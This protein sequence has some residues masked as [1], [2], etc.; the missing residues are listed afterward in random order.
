[1]WITTSG[2]AR[3]NSAAHRVRVADLD[4][5][6]AWR[7][8]ASAQQL[9]AEEPGRAGDVDPHDIGQLDG[10][11]ARRCLIHSTRNATANAIASPTQHALPGLLLELLAA[12]V[13]E[14]RRVGRPE[15]AGDDVVAEEAMPRQALR[16]AGRERDRGAPERDEPG[17]EDDVAASFLELLL[18]PVEA[19]AR[20]LVAEEPL[21]RPLAG[22]LADP[23][24]DVVADDGARPGGEDHEEDVEVA[25][26]GERAGDDHHRLARD[27]RE[28]RVE[29]GDAEDGEVAPVRARDPVDHLVEHDCILAETEAAMMRAMSLT[30]LTGM[31]VLDVTTSI[32]GPYCAQILAALGADVVK[33]ERPD[34]GDDGR[35]WGPPFW[36]GEGTMFLSANAGKRS[37]ALSLR[38]PRGR[39]ALL[40]LVDGA[41]VFLQSL[42]PGLADELGLGP[43]ALRARNPRLVYCSVGAYGHVGPL[44]HEPGYDALMQAAGGLISITG[45]PGRPGVRVGSSLIDQGT[46]TWAALGVL[47]ALLERG[48]SGEGSV[49]DVSLYETALGYIGYHLAGYLADGTVPHGQG[50]RFPM[51]APYQ[52]FPT[53]DGELMIAGGNDRLFAAI[54]DVVGLPEL[55]DDPR[56]AHEPRPCAPPG[57]ALC[58]PGSRRCREHDTAH[59]QARLTEAGVP[60]APVA[61][62]ADVAHAPQTEALGMLQHLDHPTIPDLRLTALPLSFDGERALHPSAPPAVGEHTA[63]VLREAGYEHDEIAALAAE[64]VI[65]R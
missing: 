21:H 15:P 20:L 52:V 3:A 26:A 48:R 22:Q 65:R 40:R 62:V 25:R 34:T 13:A 46:G 35:A 19:L 16:V 33:V 37:L 7:P 47:A 11:F 5:L 23:V 28:E 31:R 17:D 45:E 55:V 61:D 1:M 24:G 29:H 50:T 10:A 41:D 36:N 64:G 60:A 44:S 38:D 18:G 12:D 54:C 56:F 43:D 39:E 2:A 42:R 53:R 49:V 8:G 4:A 27:E 59:W 57:R 51:V 30:P 14:H 63:E 6:A 58:D 32:A 9:R